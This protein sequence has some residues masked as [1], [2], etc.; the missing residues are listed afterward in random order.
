MLYSD[1]SGSSVG[2]KNLRLRF[3]LIFF[4]GLIA[5]SSILYWRSKLLLSQEYVDFPQHETRKLKPALT[6]PSQIDSER[7][8]KEL[9]E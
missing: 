4:C 6:A 5:F 1:L 9:N 8:E 7:L 3:L 2:N